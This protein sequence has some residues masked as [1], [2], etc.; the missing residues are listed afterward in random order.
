MSQITAGFF[1]VELVLHSIMSAIK[2]QSVLK[3]VALA[4]FIA[5][6]KNWSGADS[7]FAC[8][9]HYSSMHKALGGYTNE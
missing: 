6:I 2:L 8:L 1:L 9:G 5:R 4:L 7:L 3:R